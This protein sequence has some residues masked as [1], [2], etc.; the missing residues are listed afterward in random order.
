[1]ADK[2]DPKE[3]RLSNQRRASTR[4]RCRQI[5]AD[6]L[7]ETSALLSPEVLSK[8]S[9]GSKLGI[10][11]EPDLVHLIPKAADRYSWW[12]QP[13]RDHLFSKQLSKHSYGAYM[14]LI[15]EVGISFEAIAKPAFSNEDSECCGEVCL[16]YFSLGQFSSVKLLLRVQASLPQ[17][18]I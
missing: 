2:T 10:V 13:E 17:S 12:R 14:E 9:A 3:A 7:S 8:Q 18:L 15:R 4:K 5:L 11:V 16:K 1:M 6:H